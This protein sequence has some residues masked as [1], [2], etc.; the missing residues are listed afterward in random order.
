MKCD[1]KPYMAPYT[2]AILSAEET[3]LRRVA[4]R[5]QLIEV[6]EDPERRVTCI[7]CGRRLSLTLAYRCLYCGFWFCP[8]CARIHFA[9][10]EGI[11]NPVVRYGVN[12][13]A[14]ENSGYRE[15]VTCK[16]EGEG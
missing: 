1:G 3:A 14:S 12:S 7:D 5:K 6:R 15:G 13:V 9:A 8:M 16:H 2:P 11:I 4:L 10:P